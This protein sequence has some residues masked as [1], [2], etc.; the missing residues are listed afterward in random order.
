VQEER[1]G[2]EAGGSDGGVVPAKGGRVLVH[3][4]GAGQRGVGAALHGPLRLRQVPHAVGAGAPGVPARPE[5]LPERGHRG[6]GAA[7]G[8]AAVPLALR[9]RG[10]LPRRHRRRA[11]ERA[12][13]GHVPGAAVVVVGAGAVGGRGGVRGGAAGVVGRAERVELH[14]RLPAGGARG[15]AP[16]ARR[17]GRHAAGGPRGAVARDPLHPQPVRAVRALLPL[18]PGR[19]RARRA[20]AR[21]RAVPQRAQHGARRRVRRGG[22]R[23]RRLRARPRRGAALGAARRRGPLVH[24]APRGRL[25]R[26]PARRLDQGAGQTLHIHRPEGVLG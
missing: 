23:G 1:G 26:R 19:R 5:A 8:G 15:A 12:V 11:V 17:G 24:Q 20:Q 16:D 21:P 18:R 25:R 7:G 4:D 14:G 6:P 9:R 13:A 3:G 10:V 22:H 2:E